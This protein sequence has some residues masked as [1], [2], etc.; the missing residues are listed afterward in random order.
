MLRRLVFSVI[1]GITVLV[2]VG[3]GA[4]LFLRRDT[5]PP[6][7][8]GD[9]PKESA[10]GP[11]V[12]DGMW[13][14]V[15]DGK[16]F[17]GYRTRERIGPISAPGDTV[18]RT[19]KLEGELAITGNTLTAVKVTADMTE[20]HSNT[21]IRDNAMK[22]AGLET[23]SFPET[24]FELTEPVREL[25]A[26]RG[27]VTEFTAVGDLTLHGVTRRVEAAIQARW[28]GP[29][30]QVA[31]NISIELSE[32]NIDVAANPVFVGLHV[33]GRGTAEF[34]LV[35][36]PGS[37][38]AGVG[39]IA[40]L[41]HDQEAPP[42]FGPPDPPCT[43][44]STPVGAV[45]FGSPREVPEEGDDLWKVNADGSGLVQLTD[46]LA[47]TELDPAASPDGT[48][49][50][51]SAIDTGTG[52]PTVSVMNA[53][54]SNQHPLITTGPPAQ[55]TPAWSPDSTKLVF[56]GG[57][58]EVPSDAQLFVANVDGT[59]IEQ[60]TTSDGRFHT[61]AAWSPD[62]ASIAYESYGQ[63]G[64]DELFV[65]SVTSRTSTRLTDDPGYDSS[66][67][68]LDSR[69]LLFSRDGRLAQ[70]D[71]ATR[72]VKL[73]ADDSVGYGIPKL[74]PDGN[75]VLLTRNGNLYTTTVDGR[76]R[77]CLAVG[78]TADYGDWLP[79]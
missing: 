14:L 51:Y 9:V 48:M 21:D 18:G 62:G 23:D 46:T 45:V 13:T 37:A 79:S 2:A 56:T 16:S 24:S 22:T 55:L 60:L 77:A 73:G 15:S 78:R 5:P 32:F 72:D 30:I 70:I 41:R 44:R 67:E 49:I 11:A 20:I 4:F 75:T 40:T 43:E 6:A 54:G 27:T 61:A 36:A 65:V 52:A 33:E 74:S 1:V 8:L 69:T 53:D 50:A 38:T 64:A 35:F 76:D 28:N 29:S 66:P 47:A 12:L 26:E 42:A 25:K 63:Q 68:W 17:V 58:L 10:G 34:E 71:V 31:G 3:V 57:N 7:R 19:T 59:G 39:E